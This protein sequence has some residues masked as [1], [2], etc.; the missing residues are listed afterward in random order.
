MLSY[1]VEIGLLG[2]DAGQE[3]EQ[4][5]LLIGA[6]SSFIATRLTNAQEP[7]TCVAARAFFAR[8]IRF[9]SPH[10][11]DRANA[12]SHGAPRR[13]SRRNNSVVSRP[14][15]GNKPETQWADLGRPT[16]IAHRT[17]EPK[18]YALRDRNRRTVHL[19]D[20]FVEAGHSQSCLL[21]AL[22]RESA[23]RGEVYVR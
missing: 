23:P 13:R 20:I 3:C 17:A 10:A 4:T 1:R 18:I 11:A 16:D 12:A 21:Y 8:L 6:R 7:W 15:C 2:R 19:G 14:S 5:H 9:T 22:A